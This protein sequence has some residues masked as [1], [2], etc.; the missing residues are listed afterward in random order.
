MPDPRQ[1]FVC[2]LCL[3]PFPDSERCSDTRWASLCKP[4]AAHARKIVKDEEDSRWTSVC[5]ELYRQTEVSKLNPAKL[6]RVM[7]WSYGPRGLLLHG[8][9]GLGKTRMMFLLLHRLIVGENRRAMVFL[10]NSFSHSAQS[11]AMENIEAWADRLN[12]VEVLFLDD[13]AKA[14]MTD[15]VEAQLFGVLE[16]RAAHCLPTLITTNAV[17]DTLEKRLSEDRGAPLVRRL[18]DF[19]EAISFYEDQ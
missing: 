1:D 10:G 4:C 15:H 12:R 13:L 3:K 6:A 11:A 2:Q 14:K 17:G 5:P 18:R 19:C 8:K 16:M 9:T 7:A